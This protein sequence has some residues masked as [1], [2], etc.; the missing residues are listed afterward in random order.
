M[1][2]SDPVRSLKQLLPVPILAFGGTALFTKLR[3]SMNLKICFGVSYARGIYICI[4]CR[5]GEYIEFV[6]RLELIYVQFALLRKFMYCCTKFKL[7]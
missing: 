5:K 4:A 3:N 2:K 1:E 7:H 6:I